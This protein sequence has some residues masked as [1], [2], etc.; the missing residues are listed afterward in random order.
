MS[1]RQKKVWSDAEVASLGILIIIIE[2]NVIIVKKED[3]SGPKEM[4]PVIQLQFYF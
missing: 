3:Y 4:A 1:M 2:I